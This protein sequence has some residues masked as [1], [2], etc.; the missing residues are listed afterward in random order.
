MPKYFTKP[1]DFEIFKEEFLKWVDTFGL[2]GW[3]LCR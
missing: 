1:W 2:K 3:E